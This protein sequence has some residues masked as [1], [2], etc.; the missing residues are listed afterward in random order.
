MLFRSDNENSSVN[1]PLKI[2]CICDELDEVFSFL[3]D[4][5]KRTQWE[6]AFRFKF[7]TYMWNYYRLSI[8]YQY[9]FLIR[10][11]RE[12][13]T[14]MNKGLYN[15]GFWTDD[16]QELLNLIISDHDMY[17][18]R[19]S[20]YNTRSKVGLEVSMNLQL[21]D[22]YIDEMVACFE[23]IIIYGAG[24]IGRKI[25]RHLLHTLNI[26]KKRIKF[27]V[28][29]DKGQSDEIEEIAI[30]RIDALTKS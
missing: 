8:P 2:F 19:S 30:H 13:Q 5:D 29:K 26:D 3:L 25:A 1:N 24:K 28:S 14:D 21:S 6:I 10:M 17:Y 27:A 23:D 4:Y 12:F 7:H 11:V 22:I 20:K 18:D 9:T 15:K 16:E